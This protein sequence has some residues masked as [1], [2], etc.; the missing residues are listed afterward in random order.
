MSSYL[1]ACLHVSAGAG[2]AVSLEVKACLDAILKID[3][4]TMSQC[5]PLPAQVSS[6][7][8]LT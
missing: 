2:I 3:Q 8:L 4:S 1:A 6:H 5:M 7:I